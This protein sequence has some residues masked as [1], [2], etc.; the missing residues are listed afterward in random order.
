MSPAG[1]AAAGRHD[2][3]RSCGMSRT[4]RA[5]RA[6]GPRH[7]ALRRAVSG[8]GRPCAPPNCVPLGVAGFPPAALLMPCTGPA[9]PLLG[10]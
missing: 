7:G 4:F 8:A 5:W 3:D 9:R 2:I 10:V 1:S 6:S